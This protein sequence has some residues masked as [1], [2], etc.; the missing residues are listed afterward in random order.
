[1]SILKNLTT[2]SS[3]KGETDSL[4]S[5]G[6]WES[7]TYPLT[8][9]VAYLSTAASGALA[10]NIVAAS[11]EKEIK[12]QFWMTSGTEKGSKNYYEKNGEKHYLPGFIAANSLALLTLGKEIGELDVE[13]KVIKVYD[14]ESKK[15]VPT[16]VDAFVDLHGQEIIAGVLKQKVDKTAKGDD[17]KYHPTGET[18]EENEIVKFFRAEDGLTVPE[19]EA[20]VTEAKFKA[21]WEKKFT[22]TVRNRAKGAEAGVKAGAPSTAQKPTKSLFA[23]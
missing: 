4:G 3:I 7:G 9:K 23:K 1:M 22:G 18:R 21:D 11:G 10:L 15:E 20:G 8:I 19:I 17:N 13:K 6:L 14:Y 12:Q 5:G 2:D 16:E